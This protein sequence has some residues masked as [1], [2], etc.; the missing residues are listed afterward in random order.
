MKPA[1]VVTTMLLALPLVACSEDEP[2]VCT[3]VEELRTSV[4]D[5]QA[6]DVGS[7]TAL[8]DLQSGLEAV[9][10]DL[11]EVK[12]DA[13]NEFAAPLEQ[14]ETSW[15]ELESSIEAATTDES[16]ETLA[17]AGQALATFGSAVQ[18]LVS[19]IQATC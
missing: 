10:G 15:A 8:A 6:I 3:S 14:V 18:T 4:D 1:L 17:A 16:P 12:A 11:A 2:A 5:V 19:D 7:G 13:E 9:E